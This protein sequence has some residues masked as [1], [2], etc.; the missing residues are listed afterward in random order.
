MNGNAEAAMLMLTG[1]RKSMK[2]KTRKK[3][4]YDQ[5][6]EIQVCA[7]VVTVLSIYKQKLLH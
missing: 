2:M 7:T 1:M 6:A 5:S 3:I 4:K